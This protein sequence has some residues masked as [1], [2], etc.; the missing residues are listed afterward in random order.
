MGVTIA[1][2]LRFRIAERMAANS[3]VSLRLMPTSGATVMIS[4]VT[5]GSLI[6]AFISEINSSALVPGSSRQSSVA[7]LADGMTLGR[8]GDPTPA[9][10]EV[11]EMVLR[12]IAE[13][14]LL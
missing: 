11:R 6:R 7:S 4:T 10:R 12:W 1:P 3:G 5:R 8:G 9:V 2:G 13:L 14:N